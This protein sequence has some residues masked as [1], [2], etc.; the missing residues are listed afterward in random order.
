MGCKEFLGSLAGDEKGAVREREK[1]RVI[2][3]MYL[4]FLHS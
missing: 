4:Y 1:I 2:S 3:N